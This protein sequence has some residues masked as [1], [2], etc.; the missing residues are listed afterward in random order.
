MWTCWSP[1]ATRPRIRST[2][3]VRQAWRSSLSEAVAT[4]DRP[5]GERRAPTVGFALPAGIFA[6]WTPHIP[7][8]KERLGLDNGTLGLALLGAPLG[9]VCAMLVAGSAVSRWGSRPV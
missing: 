4:M 6:A 9:A 8:V 1:T 5:R 2:S 7:R 3:S